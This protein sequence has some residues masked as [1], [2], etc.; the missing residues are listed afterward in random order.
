MNPIEIIRF[1]S[2][3][4]PDHYPM[5]KIR[6][7]LK[8]MLQPKD[9]EGYEDENGMQ[10]RWINKDGS[11][12]TYKNDKRE[13]QYY[14]Y[15]RHK[16]ELKEKGTYVNGKKNGPFEIYNEN[17][18]KEKGIYK[19]DHKDGL[20]D[21][22]LTY[23]PNEY[24]FMSATLGEDNITYNGPFI[25]YRD[26]GSIYMKGTYVN[27]EKNGPFEIYYDDGKISEKGTFINGER[28]GPFIDYD[29]NGL[30]SLKGTYVDNKINGPF[31]TYYNG[32]I[33]QKGTY[34]DNKEIELKY[35]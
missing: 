24:P 29:K 14:I 3:N 13:G 19:N 8:N 1:I 28:N 25:H 2:K 9:N 11:I 21:F 18:L 10:G 15:D 20:V 33:Y 12:F 22:Y 23:R 16:Q 5:D 6:K 30:I 26:N 34:V 17:R 27:G 32:E 7:E 31:E 4:R 35:V